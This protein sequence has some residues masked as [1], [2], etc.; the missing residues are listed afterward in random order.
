VG[1][2]IG[3]LCA[4]ILPSS[5][6]GLDMTVAAVQSAWAGH[7]TFWPQWC[8]PYLEP[9]VFDYEHWGR[10]I[11]VVLPMGL[12][13]LAGS[14]QNIESAAAGGDR[15]HTGTSLA[16]NGIG[17]IAAACF[18]SCFPTTIY[19]GHPGWK[20]LGARA[21]YSTL[22][23]LVITAICLTGT[24]GLLSSIVPIEAGI[25]IVLWIGIVITAQAYQAT[26]S[27]HAPAVA[28]GLFPAIAAWGATIV[29]GTLMA[30]QAAAGA[31]AGAAGV[32]GAAPAAVVPTLQ[33]LL[34]AG[35]AGGGLDTQ[36]GGFLVHGMI[37]LERGYIFT[38][39]ILAAIGAALIDRK[40]YNAAIWSL[41]AGLCTALGLMHA[42]QVSGNE[43]DFLFWLTAVHDG[44]FAYRP[45]TLAASYGLAAMLFWA[46]GHY[47][48]RAEEA[49]AMPLRKE[50]GP[51]RRPA[52]ESATATTASWPPAAEPRPPSRP[53]SAVPPSLVPRHTQTPLVAPTVPP[54]QA[55]GTGLPSPLPP[56]P[57]PAEPAPRMVPQPGTSWLEPARQPPLIHQ[58]P[59]PL[60]PDPGTDDDDSRI[61]LLDPDTAEPPEG[62]R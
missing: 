35:T 43:I 16:V 23:G 10:L 19:I 45:W 26:P 18:G 59:P 52:P 33:Q 58:E 55:P 61:V 1:V 42:Y 17:T 2:L 34:Q 38:C 44:A 37:I 12:F 54:A 20:K 48:L 6:T 24:V 62:E 25:A 29:A 56:P 32:A 60:P 8:W 39:M 40:F 22:N 49:A 36:A 5:L 11:S 31:G 28:L 51:S 9:L 57:P 7:G 15:F 3:T 41:L 30:A 14:L 50:A 46:F 47:Y 27:E 21:G 13:N 53:V 4:W